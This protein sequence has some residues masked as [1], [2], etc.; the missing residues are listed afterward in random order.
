M[1]TALLD[2]IGRHSEITEELMRLEPE[3]EPEKTAFLEDSMNI[4][5]IDKIYIK[6]GKKNIN[7]HSMKSFFPEY[8]S[9]YATENQ[10]P[11]KD[12]L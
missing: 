7:E 6:N 10:H 8:P 9:E 5:T 4:E 2:F 1:K 11:L 3:F 12:D